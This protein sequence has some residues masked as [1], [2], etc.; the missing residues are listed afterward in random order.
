MRLPKEHLQIWKIPS[1]ETSSNPAEH[2]TGLDHEQMNSP[3]R[4]YGEPRNPHYPLSTSG[5]FTW[6]PGISQC[7]H[8][9]RDLVKPHIMESRI[10]SK[11]LWRG[12][13]QMIWETGAAERTTRRRAVHE[14]GTSIKNIRNKQKWWSAPLHT[15]T[16]HTNP[17]KKFPEQFIPW[18]VLS[19]HVVAADA[20]LDPT[21]NSLHT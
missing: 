12:E 11:T 1:K 10:T 3:P 15:P 17:H 2:M 21:L 4:K 14:I 19:C 8:L 6:I 9:G 7:S 13:E 5:H 20:L 18:T 16:P